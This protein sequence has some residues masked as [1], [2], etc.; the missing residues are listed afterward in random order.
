MGFLRPISTEFHG[1]VP[2]D[3]FSIRGNFT[4]MRTPVYSAGKLEGFLQ[5]HQ[6]A[7]LKE[8]KSTLGTASTMTVLRKLQA[9][10]YLSSYSHRGSY[11]SLRSIAD[12]DSLG[13]W[14][15]GSICF[16]KHGNLLKTIK[17]LVEQ[18]DAGLSVA[19]LDALL[20]VETKHAALRLYK[21][22]Q[23]H[24][25]KCGGAWVYLACEQAKKRRQ[26]LMRSQRSPLAEQSRAIKIDKNELRAALVLFYSL[27]NE[28]QRR[29]FAGLESLKQGHGGDRYIADLL[30]LDAHTVARGRQELLGDELKTDRVRKK[31]GGRKA[32]EKKRPG[33]SRRSKN[34]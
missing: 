6:V 16:S 5:E 23:V 33:S 19:E 20:H 28:K 31:G 29:L 9:L 27:L 14:Q 34:S 32:M 21:S 26:V 8:L 15:Q 17:A 4:I 3:F 25:Q 13:L 2:L 7:T 30:G 11:Y 22:A 10:G 24:R 1:R 18:S 12:F